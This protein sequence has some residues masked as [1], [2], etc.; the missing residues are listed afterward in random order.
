MSTAEHPILLSFVSACPRERSGS[1]T[2]NRYDYQLCWAFCTLLDLHA[3][4]EAY[5]LVLDYHDD[6]VIFDSESQPSQAKFYQL[7][8][9]GSG[10][11]SITDLLRV[12]DGQTQ[13]ILG[14]LYAHHIMFG[15]LTKSLNMVSNAQFTI[16]HKTSPKKTKKVDHCTLTDL[17]WNSI[18][19]VSIALQKEHNL[20]FC[21]LCDVD[22]TLRTDQLS[23]KEP[24]THAKGRFMDFIGNR[25]VGAVCHI[26]HAFNAIIDELQKR[27]SFEMQITSVSDLL[28][29]KGISRTEFS[30]ILSK[31]EQAAQPERWNTIE[32]YLIKGG[33]DLLTIQ[34]YRRKW[35]T[36]EVQRLDP[37]NIVLRQ[38]QSIIQKEFETLLAYENPDPLVPFLA[39]CVSQYRAVA[40]SADIPIDDSTIIGIILSL[41]S[42]K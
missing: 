27:S 6:V 11:W 19:E 20:C 4:Q 9:K 18:K 3:S 39:K 16:R 1:R 29:K 22:T 10:T 26:T 37:A 24:R 34:Q 7:K 31:I 30:Q 13:S 35:G 23:S 14:K 8:V 40:R 33:V 15:D 12:K 28:N 2:Q 36:Y 41:L 42:E 5:L 38:T 25:N 21:P 17:C 32:Q